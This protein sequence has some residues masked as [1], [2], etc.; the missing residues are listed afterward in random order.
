[1]AE[2]REICT[3]KFTPRL[4]PSRQ[5]GHK[6]SHLRHVVVVVNNL[7]IKLL[8]VNNKTIANTNT[9]KSNLID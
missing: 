6:L 7:N 5:T 8:K 2:H 4:V 9:K 3:T 1:M